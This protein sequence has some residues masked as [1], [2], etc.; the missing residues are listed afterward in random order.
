MAA[1]ESRRALPAR[2][3]LAVLAAA[4]VLPGLFGHDPW[5][6]FDAIGIEVAHQMLLGGDWLVPQVAGEAWLDYPPLF[7]WLS[8]AFAWAGSLVLPFHDAARIAGGL[9][10]A[11]AFALL[12]RAGARVAPAERDG[13]VAPAVI[14]ALLLPG[15]VGLM[16]HAHEAVAELAGLAACAAALAVLPHRLQRPLSG[17][18]AFGAA[19]GAAFLS[20]GPV[21]PAALMLAVLATMAACPE[22]RTRRHL[23]WAAVALAVLGACA[24]SWPLALRARDPALLDAWWSL[25]LRGR[26]EFGSGM[27][28]LLAMSTWFL[29]PAWPL[30]LWTL[31]VL[32]RSLRSAAVF[33]PLAASVLLACGLAA[34]GPRQDVA[35]LVLIPPLAL[36]ASQGVPALRRGAA[37]ALDW[38]GVMCFTF[39]AAMIWLGYVAMQSGWPP[40]VAN[41]FAKTAPGYLPEF[42]WLPLVVAMALA[43]GWLS[44]AFRMRPSAVRG[45]TRWAAGITLV[46]GSFAMLWLPWA[47]YQKS[48]RPV[49][50]QLK[51]RLPP[52]EACVA[53][54][55]LGTPQR[56]ALSYHAGLRTHPDSEGRCRY[57]L[58]QGSPAH[59]TMP[60]SGKGRWTKVSDIGRPGDKL[61][62]FRLYRLDRASR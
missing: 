14:A 1:E 12:Y 57:L 17:G 36:L 8:A 41:N 60:V 10:V 4:F 54:Q 19:L 23:V 32:R 34:F 22:W 50:L 6:S 2:R 45:V 42:E 31:W 15:C 40:K 48:Y 29:W 51:S 7:Y 21:L 33:A 11:A 52:G 5:K 62:R 3:W 13:P 28:N 55:G 9:C 47:D 24:L 44:I 25:A 56:A 49:A 43:A 61:E 35:L 37:A 38:F 30:A 20:T 53:G 59:E 26:G 46:W 27:A 18:A 58:V 39:F 16:V